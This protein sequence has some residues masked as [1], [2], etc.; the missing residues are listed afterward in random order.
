L[1]NINI[2]RRLIFKVAAFCGAL[3]IIG[4]AFADAAQKTAI[5]IKLKKESSMSTRTLTYEFYEAF[6]RVEF[7][8]WDSIIAENVLIN[9][10]AGY[11]LKGLDTFKGFATQFTDLGY[12]IDLVDE[13]LALDNY[14][15]GRGFITFVLHWKHAMD[16]GGLAPTGREG[17][18]VETILFTIQKNKIVRMDVADNTL[19]LV[20]YLWER[21]WAM[22]HNI[23]P[24][25]I[26]VGI[27][28]RTSVTTGGRSS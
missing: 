14:G 7:N 11:G 2:T 26:V 20:I 15:T 10:P 19:D 17:T 24:E 5:P 6:Q 18:S 8:R 25:P 3:P 28:R 22:P 16:F 23:R 4:G 12:Q 21:N 13:H 27:D 1:D 9:S